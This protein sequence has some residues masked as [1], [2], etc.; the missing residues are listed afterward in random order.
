MANTFQDILKKV[1]ANKD[2]LISELE[3]KEDKEM[4]RLSKISK[5]GRPAKKQQHRPKRIPIIKKESKG[6]ILEPWTTH[7]DPSS[8]TLIE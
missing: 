2:S 3:A 4:K 1:K 5:V 6:S 8:S 7:L